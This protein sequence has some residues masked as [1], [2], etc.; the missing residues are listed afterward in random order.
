MICTRLKY[1]KIVIFLVL[2]IPYISI[3]KNVVGFLK[4]HS[5][6]FLIVNAGG[7]ACNYNMKAKNSNGG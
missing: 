3:S 6:F 7:M 4:G 2:I 5:M 1:V